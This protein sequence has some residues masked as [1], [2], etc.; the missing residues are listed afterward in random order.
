[1]YGLDILGVLLKK[2]WENVYGLDIPGV[3][4]WNPNPR[5]MY[6]WGILVNVWNI[7][8]YI[9]NMIYKVHIISYI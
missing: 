9:C 8:I 3:C 2:P 7:H 4:C 1:M 5:E 6:K